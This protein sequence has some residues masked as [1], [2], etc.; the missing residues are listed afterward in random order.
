MQ[1][2]LCA[3]FQLTVRFTAVLADL[4]PKRLCFNKGNNSLSLQSEPM[5]LPL[6]LT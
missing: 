6:S 4:S 1:A 5:S 3:D 2:S